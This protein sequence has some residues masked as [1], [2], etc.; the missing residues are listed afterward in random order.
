MAQA[1]IGSLL[2][3]LGM[4]AGEFDKNVSKA[5][6][7]M[8]KLEMHLQ[9]AASVAKA[10]GMAL[11]GALAGMATGIAVGVRSAINMADEMDEMAQ[12]V[13]LSVEALS[14]LR[15]AAE[16]SGVPIDVLST[17]VRKLSQA[18]EVVA[19]GDVTGAVARS[20]AA[21]GVS[22]TS[23]N[24]QLRPTED[25][26]IDIAE[27]FARAQDGAGKTAIAMN[28]FGK[29]GAELIPFLNQGRAGIAALTDE[30]DKFGVTLSG[31]TAKAAGEFNE[32]LDK[33]A[34]MT[35]GA[36]NRLAGELLPGLNSLAQYLETSASKFDGLG[37]ATRLAGY[38]FDK[39]MS[40]LIA[41]DHLLQVSIIRL[42][43]YGAA[44]MA[45]GQLDFDAAS[46]AWAKMTNDLIVQSAAAEAAMQKLWNSMT[47]AK[48]AA[49]ASEL[50]GFE[51]PGAKK[52]DKDA[53]P[54]LPIIQGMTDLTAARKLDNEAA[55]LQNQLQAEATALM[56]EHADPMQLMALE[57]DRIDNLQ[58]KV[59][60]SAQVAGAAM[61]KA[62]MT[63]ANAYGQAAQ[64]IMGNLQGVFGEAKGFA[65]AQALINTYE[66]V[67]A[68]LKGPPGPPWSYAIAASALAA[69]M[70]QVNAIRST[71][72]N[73]GGG[74]GGMASGAAANTGGGP[75]AVPQLLTVR[76][77]NPSDMFS[78]AQMRELA[79]GMLAYQRDGGEVFIQ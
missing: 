60:L 32:H 36:F 33:M 46:A 51:A 4:D 39:F 78:G 31:S 56:K 11:A 61:Q 24:G 57:L 30:A 6:Q 62:A 64:K 1:V 10:A 73:G 70:A 20:L 72:K 8:D 7:Q 19:S 50:Q 16:I 48:G 74:G 5:G 55:T 67:T 68:A 69:G 14:R 66:A 3:Q 15:Y 38:A 77:I 12:K 23:A 29:S 75:G 49:G 28:I 25:V 54:F 47:P 42:Q 34:Q 2:V 43:G 65:I 17:G 63:A 59:G 58:R 13:G 41:V 18:M 76:G 21:L 52:D 45:V 53:K 37:Y 44:L 27:A 79:N 40:Y 35:K 9:R 26:L 71:T 22:A